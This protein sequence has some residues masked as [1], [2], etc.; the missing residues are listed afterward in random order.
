SGEVHHHPC[1]PIRGE[2][3]VVGAGDS[4]MA[5]LASAL[6]AQATIPEALAL[7]SAAASIV[8]H[9]LGTTGSANVTQLR[10]LLGQFDSVT[11]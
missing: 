6:A 5:N 3:D 9:Q 4:V 1:F 8:V 11:T 2:I 10:E 7:A